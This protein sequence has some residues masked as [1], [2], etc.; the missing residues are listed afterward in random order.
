[1]IG[2]ILDG[3]YRVLAKIG[4]GSMGEVYLVEHETLQRR[5]ALKVLHPVL[6]KDSAFV[7]RFRREARAMNRLQHP[8]IVAVHDFGRLPAS[9][10]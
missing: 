2:A 10:S 7:S 8:E 3:R 5:E 4:A 6:A 1:V 9:R